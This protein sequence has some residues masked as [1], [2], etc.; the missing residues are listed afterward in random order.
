MIIIYQ[1]LSDYL[2]NTGNN[3]CYDSDDESN[4]THLDSIEDILNYNK[5]YCK[6]SQEK[7]EII[8][9]SNP[10]K[11]AIDFGASNEKTLNT[12]FELLEDGHLLA[13]YS[14][15][16]LN[17][18]VVSDIPLLKYHECK[19]S[20]TNAT[21]NNI[22]SK[23]QPSPK[24]ILISEFNKFSASCEEKNNKIVGYLPWKLIKSDILVHNLEND[25]HK[26]IEPKIREVLNQIDIITAQPTEEER[27]KKYH[28]F[29]PAKTQ[30]PTINIEKIA[31][32]FDD[33]E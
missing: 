21:T 28:E 9:D 10:D 1:K 22:P 29:Y 33:M 18:T 31:V 20:R 16:V 15:I 24:S 14:N 5:R 11:K 19:I 32:L 27:H 17:Y 12:M 8:A 6:F 25:W 13:E 4:E 23:I 30:K 26:K 7:L 2:H 3:S